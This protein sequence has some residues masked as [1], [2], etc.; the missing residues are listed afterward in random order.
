MFVRRH[1]ELRLLGQM[2]PVDQGVMVARREGALDRLIEVDGPVIGFAAR[3]LPRSQIVHEVARTGDDHALLTQGT[4]ALG[5]FIMRADVDGAIQRQL[6]HGHVS[7]RPDMSQHGPGS[8]IQSPLRR[9]NRAGQLR[10]PVGQSGRAGRRILHG[11]KFR[12]KAP[13]IMDGFRSRLRRHAQ[14]ARLPV[15]RDHDDAFRLADLLSQRAPGVRE[16]T[17]QG[18]HGGAVTKKECWLAHDINRAASWA[19]RVQGE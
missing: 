7:V 14:P 12:R 9:L 5:Q 10:H 17:A 1:A 3:P 15:S 2:H 13:E 19:L 18:V 6:H 4:Q 8:V 11:V 16:G